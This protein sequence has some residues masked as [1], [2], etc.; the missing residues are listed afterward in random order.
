MQSY[1]FFTRALPLSG[2]ALAAALSVAQAQRAAAPFE[3]SVGQ[4]G[5]DVVW[6]PTSQALV[7]RMLDTA[8]VTPNDF[9]MDSAPATAAP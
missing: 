2:L 6:V 9:V 7:D 3:P 5:K 8:K 4:P 1:K